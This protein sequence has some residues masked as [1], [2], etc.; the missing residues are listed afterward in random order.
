MTKKSSIKKGLVRL[1]KKYQ[2]YDQTCQISSCTGEG[3]LNLINPV[4]YKEDKEVSRQDINTK[5]AFFF[6]KYHSRMYRRYKQD[7]PSLEDELDPTYEEIQTL[8]PVDLAP[9][10]KTGNPRPQTN[11]ALRQQNY[12]TF[13]HHDI[14][15]KNL[16]CMVS[17]CADR[18]QIH[19]PDFNNHREVQPVCTRHQGEVDET[20][21]VV[22]ASGIKKLKQLEQQMKDF[23]ATI[24]KLENTSSTDTR[25]ESFFPQENRRQ[26]DRRKEDRETN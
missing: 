14:D 25:Q 6:C 17:D 2:V 1:L 15:I 19:I 13:R 4:M 26:H 3:H 9:L 12:R 18:A 21:N 8:T 10:L 23:K 24:S 11:Q 5:E 20:I 16:Q 22:T 7:K